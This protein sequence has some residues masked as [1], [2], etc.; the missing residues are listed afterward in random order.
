MC[1]KYDIASNSYSYEKHIYSAGTTSDTCR[2][3]VGKE[4]VC[5]RFNK[6][7]TPEAISKVDEATGF[8]IR[9]EVPV[10]DGCE[11]CTGTRTSD[12]VTVT[13]C[14]RNGRCYGPDNDDANVN[15]NYKPN[16]EVLLD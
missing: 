1:G 4:P 5:Y 11:K 15:P 2:T 13:G 9:S 3:N 10:V 12:S 14:K 6:T 8:I 16:V 7:D